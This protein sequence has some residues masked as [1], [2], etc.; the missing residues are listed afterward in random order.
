MCFSGIK[1]DGAVTGREAMVS[2]EVAFCV[3]V[4]DEEAMLSA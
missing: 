4:E 2:R 1:G 3:D